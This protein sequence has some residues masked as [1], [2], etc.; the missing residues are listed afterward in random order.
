MNNKEDGFTLV[1]SLITLLITSLLIFLPILS[2]DRLIHSIE[3]DMFFRELSS[4]ITL[5]QNHAILTG[6]STAIEFVPRTNLIK[7]KAYDGS[8]NSD[9]PLNRELL[10]DDS[11]CKFY[12]NET[13]IVYFKANTGNIS[14]LYDRWRIKFETNKVLYELVFKIGSGRFDIRKI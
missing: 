9:H 8:Y 2:I 6:E 5:M 14:V 12:G 10:L 11:I 1:E 4:N 13:Q 7:F 3:V